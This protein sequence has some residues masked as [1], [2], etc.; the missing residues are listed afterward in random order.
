MENGYSSRRAECK[1]SVEN[2]QSPSRV[3]G[4]KSPQNGQQSPSRV[5][6]KESLEKG[7]QSTSRIRGK[8]SLENGLVARINRPKLCMIYAFFDIFVQKSV[9]DQN[10]FLTAEIILTT[11]GPL[12]SCL[13]CQK[14]LTLK[15]YSNPFLGQRSI[16]IINMH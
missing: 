15:F 8:K 11:R 5:G 1:N 3:R 4:K 10:Y 7:Q 12:Y 9:F 16:L 6:G 2:E 14:M 13:V